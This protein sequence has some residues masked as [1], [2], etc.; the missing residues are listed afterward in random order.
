MFLL[1]RT[2]QG[3]LN[4]PPRT[5]NKYK[6]CSILVCVCVWEAVFKFFKVLPWSFVPW[7]C[8]TMRCSNKFLIVSTRLSELVTNKV[9]L[10]RTRLFLFPDLYTVIVKHYQGDWGTR[11]ALR[12]VW[13]C[14][15]VDCVRGKKMKFGMKGFSPMFLISMKL[16]VII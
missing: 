9:W 8:D 13:N 4:T 2:F 6:M 1:L 3:F 7:E 12:I 10:R 11:E 14:G 5:P 16:F 15:H